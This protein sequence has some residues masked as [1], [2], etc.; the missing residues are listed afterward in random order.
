M[1]EGLILEEGN[2]EGVLKTSG[3][4]QAILVENSS[5]GYARMVVE[6]DGYEDFFMKDDNSSIEPLS[7]LQN[8]QTLGPQ[9]RKPTRWA[10]TLHP[11]GRGHGPIRT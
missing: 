4:I 1:V 7:G 2:Q 11:E 8:F 3:L 10:D 6:S 9:R 5:K